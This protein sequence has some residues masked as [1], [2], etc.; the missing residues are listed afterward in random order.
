MPPKNPKALS[1]ESPEVQRAR[2]ALGAAVRRALNEEFPG[3]D[4]YPQ[5]QRIAEDTGLNYKTI[6]RT[7]KGETAI[8]FNNLVILARRLGRTVSELTA[9]PVE[10]T[11]ARPGLRPN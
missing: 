3:M 11:A 4:L 7:A 8:S 6:V 10:K 2:A 1:T 5:C 9:L